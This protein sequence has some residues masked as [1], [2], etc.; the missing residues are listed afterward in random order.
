M[1]KTTTSATSLHTGTPATTPMNLKCMTVQ[2]G[3]VA[4]TD[5]EPTEVMILINPRGDVTPPDPV[6]GW[7][8]YAPSAGKTWNLEDED[9]KPPRPHW[10]LK[11]MNVRIYVK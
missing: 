4:A 2:S 8:E 7:T 5:S 10:P 1:E 9:Q 6:E 3:T 11:E